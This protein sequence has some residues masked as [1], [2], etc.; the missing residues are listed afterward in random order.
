MS[1]FKVDNEQID[2]TVETL[3]TLLTKCEE[4][5]EKEVPVSDVDKGQTHEEL[6]SVCD[7]I[8]TTC[9]YFGQLIH[10]TIEFL[11]KSSEMFAKSDTNSANAIKDS[12]SGTAGTGSSNSKK[13]SEEYKGLQVPLKGQETNYTCGSASGN[14]ILESLGVNCSESEFWNYANSNGQGTYVYRIAQTL[15]HFIGADAYKYVY[16]S[17]MNLDEY[18]NT[19][20]TSIN[21]GYPV[22]VVMSIPSGSAFGYSTGGHYAVV[23]GVYKNATGEYIAK[24]NDPFSGNWYNNGHQGQQIEV[25]LSDIQQYNRNHSGYIICN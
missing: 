14:M 7:N 20:S 23:T 5:Y 10:N 19:I 4:L 2:A 11:G 12:S 22:E 17:G 1:K 24:V 13:E 3:K 18:Y 21:N 8:R 25:K 9:Y 6:I 16:T 15:N